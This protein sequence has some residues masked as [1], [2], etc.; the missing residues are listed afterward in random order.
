MKN[1]LIKLK[2]KFSIGISLYNMNA[3]EWEKILTKYQY[4]IN[5]IFF[6][7]IESIDFQTRRNIYNYEKDN[8]AEI[9]NQLEYVLDIARKL[10]ISL[11]LVLNVPNFL[12]NSDIIIRI[13][14]KYK[15]RYNMDYVTTFYNCAKRIREI[16]SDQKI[17]CSYNQGIKNH[18][19]LENLLSSQIFNTVV[20]GNNFYRDFKSFDLIHRYEHK[21]ELLLNNGCMG[22]CLSFCR[23]PNKYCINN[24]EKNLNK[25]NINYLYAEAS[26]FPEEIHKYLLPLDLID[27]FKL[28]TRPIHLKTLDDMLN[29]YITADSLSYINKRINNYH[30]YGRLTHFYPYYNSLDYEQIMSYKYDIW[31]QSK[32]RY[33][34]V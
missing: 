4:Y 24:F 25:T 17:V 33:Y 20:I 11:K 21:I 7:P 13:Y 27:Y 28:S 26:M 10:E 5:D 2:K 22:D 6:S 19:E 31:E 12:D 3:E 9:K 34:E 8:L 1:N 15:Y 16:D 30:M 32:N 23:M 18:I 29:S 14:E